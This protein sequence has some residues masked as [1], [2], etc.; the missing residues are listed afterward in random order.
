MAHPSKNED[1]QGG[2]S[3][4]HHVGRAPEQVGGQGVEQTLVARPLAPRC[5]ALAT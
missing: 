5:G 3:M 4:V 1:E 2:N